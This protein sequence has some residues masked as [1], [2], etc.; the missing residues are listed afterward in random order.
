M[1][2]SA[3][4]STLQGRLEALERTIYNKP[5]KEYKRKT[6][7]YG[8]TLLGKIQQMDNKY[9]EIN[10][11]VKDFYNKYT[12]LRPYLNGKQ[13]FFTNWATQK[14]IILAS[15]PQYKRQCAELNELEKLTSVLDKTFKGDTGK[16]LGEVSKIELGTADLFRDIQNY[17]ADLDKFLTDYNEVIQLVSEKFVSIDRQ[18]SQWEAGK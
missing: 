12:E 11:Q 1:E 8:G 3:A 17:R 16:L 13:E 5:Y 18:L 14:A 9:K 15:A 6:E 10:D 7:S 4:L 2:E